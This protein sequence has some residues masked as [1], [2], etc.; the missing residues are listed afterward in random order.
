MGDMFGVIG[1]DEEAIKALCTN[2]PD[3][4][5]FACPS[6]VWKSRSV[7]N[8]EIK[9]HYRPDRP[10]FERHLQRSSIPSYLS[11][12]AGSFQSTIW[13][14]RDD[15]RGGSGDPLVSDVR[16]ERCEVGDGTVIESSNT[17]TE[18]GEFKVGRP[19]KLIV[20]SGS[21]EQSSALDRTG[22]RGGATY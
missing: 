20:P 11:G 15:V 22:Q 8:Y 1:G 17:L 21:V 10:F 16:A 3:L 7:M 4:P 5:S 18:S 12:I 19:G 9:Q 14:S 13:Q 2:H 6:D